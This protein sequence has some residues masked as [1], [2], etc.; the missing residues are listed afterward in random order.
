MQR[1][2]A[3]KALNRLIQASA[4]DMTK[5]AMVDLYKA[6]HL[7]LLQVHDELAF[8]VESEGQA[9]ELA[10]IMCNAIELKVPMKTDIEMGSS[11]GAS[12]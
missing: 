1:A 12:M 7:P 3:Y 8:S 11:W 9:K 5:K 6:G 4:A 10:E 2:Y